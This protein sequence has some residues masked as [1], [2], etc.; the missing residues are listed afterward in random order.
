MSPRLLARSKLE[1]LAV[2]LAGIALTQTQAQSAR[3][4]AERSQAYAA[5]P[6]VIRPA[7]E[8]GSPDQVTE[9]ERRLG[10]VPLDWRGWEW[11]VLDGNS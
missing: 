6:A 11:L 8:T 3:L 10:A 7:I 5:E 2:G 9:V 1:A 4:A